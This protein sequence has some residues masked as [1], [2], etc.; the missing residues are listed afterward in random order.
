MTKEEEYRQILGRYYNKQPGL[1]GPSY[2]E[3]FSDANQQLKR[4]ND[5]WES[6]VD[7]PNISKEEYEEKVAE[8]KAQR[9]NALAGGLVTG[10]TGATTLLSN[11]YRDSQIRDTEAQEYQI[12]NL[13]N[14]GNYN[15]NN[16]D[17]LASD[18]ANTDFGKQFGYDDI[19][20]MSTGQQVGSVATS[21]LSGAMTG[22]QVGG[23][24]GALIG[25]AIGLG[26][27]LGGVAYGNA[28][29][30]IK[31]DS[32]NTNALLASDAAQQN[33]GAAHE[34]ISASR[35]RQGMVNSVASGGNIQ[36]RSQSIREYANKMLKKSGSNAR[37]CGGKIV[38]VRKEG[39]VCVRIKY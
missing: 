37:N 7:S 9:G 22:L 36:R 29:A 14:A 13:A 38:R 27:G 21:T 6:T 32:L 23:P 19:R 26:T 8:L 12:A 18:Y 15:Y 2:A 20:G 35:A 5:W 16:Y 4:W 24:W 17:Q 31:Q 34:R 30:K 25:G 28:T 33:F 3:S 11:A 1:F 10:L 39:G